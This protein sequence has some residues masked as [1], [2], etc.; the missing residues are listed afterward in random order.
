MQVVIAPAVQFPLSLS[1]LLNLFSEPMHVCTLAH[2][3]TLQRLA[4][5]STFWLSTTFLFFSEPMQV[6]IAP[7]FQFPMDLCSA[8]AIQPISFLFVVSQNSSIQRKLQISSP[9]FPLLLFTLSNT[10]THKLHYRSTSLSQD[11]LQSSNAVNLVKL[12]ASLL[13]VQDVHS[14]WPKVRKG[15]PPG[16]T[17]ITNILLSTTFLPN[18]RYKDHRARLTVK[19]GLQKSPCSSIHLERYGTIALSQKGNA[20]IQVVFTQSPVSLTTTPEYL[21][22]SGFNVP[23]LHL[24]QVSQTTATVQ[25]T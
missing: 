19:I 1:L 4:I 7:A 22:V 3:W 10:Q 13:V 21:P 9:R 11:P 25:V 14:T 23:S 24:S 20:C 15:N 18:R 12:H 8:S 6:V 16:S 2:V 17:N 5:W